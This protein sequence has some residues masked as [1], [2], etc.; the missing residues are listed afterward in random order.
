MD[1]GDARIVLNHADLQRFA[2]HRRPYE[3]RD[4]RIVGFEC[5]PVMSNCMKHVIVCDA[6]L[7]RSWLDVHDQ[8]VRLTNEI[9]NIC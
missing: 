5:S 3:H 6:V 8:S 4:R 7:A 9:V 1:H 2:S